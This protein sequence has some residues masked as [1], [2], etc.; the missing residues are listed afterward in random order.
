MRCYHHHRRRR[1]R[2]RPRQAMEKMVEDKHAMQR[3][4][5]ELKAAL[6]TQTERANEAEERASQLVAGASRL[7]GQVRG[8]RE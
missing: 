4:L 7:R 3:Q 8:V 1:R 2:R 6:A 5:A